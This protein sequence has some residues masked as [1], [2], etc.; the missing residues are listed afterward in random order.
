MRNRLLALILLCLSASEIL[1]VYF[2]M[3]FPGSQKEEVVGWAYGL[4]RSIWW[5]RI[6]GWSLAL[7]IWVMMR[8]PTIGGTRPTKGGTRSASE[9]TRWSWKKTLSIALWSLGIA[10]YAFVFY[11]F[12]FRF[13]A[14]RMFYQ[15]THK[16]FAQVDAGTILP[17][18]YDSTTLV[19]G[20][21]IHGQACAYP[22]NII[23]YHHQVR[24]TVGG[25]PIMV[26]YC[27]VCRTGRVFS[28]EVKG[29]ITNF[30]LVGMDHF[31]AM[32]EDKLTHSWWRQATG[33]AVTGP[34]KGIHLP[35]IYSRQVTLSSWLKQ[36]P[37]SQILLPDPQYSQQYASLEGYDK[38]TLHSMLEGRDSTSGKAKSW[39]VGVLVGH[40]CAAYDWN[41]FRDQGLIEDTLHGEPFVLFLEKDA[42]SFHAFDRSLKGVPL[43]FQRIDS[44][45]QLTDIQTHSIWNPYGYCVGG[46]LKGQ[47][48]EPIRAYQEFWHSWR[49]FHP[50]AQRPVKPALATNRA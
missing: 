43:Q 17:A 38:G 15:P 4:D 21:A 47:R 34:S 10:F 45:G 41:R 19:L 26:T 48:L 11:V 2:I 8:S 35:E 22:I 3:P 5:I 42:Q 7:A 9:S 29:Q 20:V 39:V 33:E 40:H 30:R 37:S 24:D 12:N 27:T 32:F 14:D 36:Y 16:L 49:T 44:T 18:G 13:E 50:G 25:V 46:C 31:N 23:G 1:R 6:I 28:P